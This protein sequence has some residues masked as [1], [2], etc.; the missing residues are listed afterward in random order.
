MKVFQNSPCLTSLEF[1]GVTYV[2]TYNHASF[3]KALLGGIYNCYMPK[4]FSF[5]DH[6]GD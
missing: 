4:M 6:V 3:L 2:I 1:N 5:D